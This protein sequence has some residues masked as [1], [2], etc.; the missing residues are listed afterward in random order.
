MEPCI[1]TS[2]GNSTTVQ[3][4]EKGYILNRKIF[5]ND[6]AVIAKKDGAV[7]VTD[8]YVNGLLIKNNKIIGAKVVYKNKLIEMKSKLVIGADGVESRIG[9]MAG[10]NTK[11]NLNI[12]NKKYN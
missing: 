9:Q 1:C 5:D 12:F 4:Q 6:L 3:F 7:V 2:D 8:A 11:I 10:I